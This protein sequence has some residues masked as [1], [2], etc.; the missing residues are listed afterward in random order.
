MKKMVVCSSVL[1]AALVMGFGGGAYA[2]DGLFTNLTAEGVSALHG[3]VTIGQSMASAN[4][5]IYG[6]LTLDETTSV[7]TLGH[8]SMRPDADN[9]GVIT[10]NDPESTEGG[11]LCGAIRNSRLPILVQ[12]M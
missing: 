11:A 6:N 7:I 4:L 8:L 5:S 1:F 10:F 3:N 9:G 2:T 12:I